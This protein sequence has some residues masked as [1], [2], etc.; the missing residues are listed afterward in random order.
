MTALGSVHRVLGFVFMAGVLVQFFLAGL[1]LF[2]AASFAPHGIFG[3]LLVLFSLIILLLALASG[4]G[5]GVSALLFVFTVIQMV[6]VWFSED[7]P[8]VSA[9]HP[10]NALFLLY[11]GHAV[12]RGLSV[13]ELMPGGRS[14]GAPEPAPRVR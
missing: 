2:G 12:G 11:L 3:S 5:R 4:R 14:S 10:V 7:A 13:N 6:L 8:V 1:G 9:L